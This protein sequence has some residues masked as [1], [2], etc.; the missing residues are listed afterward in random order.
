MEGTKTMKWTITAD[1]QCMADIMQ[2]LGRH[3]AHCQKQLTEPYADK[4]YWEKRVKHLEAAL[5]QVN[6]APWHCECDDDKA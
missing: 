1:L 3:L 2:S 4:A 5:G 6:A